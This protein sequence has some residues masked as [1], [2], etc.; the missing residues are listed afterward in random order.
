MC[1]KFQKGSSNLVDYPPLSSTTRPA[2]MSM[3]RVRELIGIP[4]SPALDKVYDCI[5]HYIHRFITHSSFITIASAHSDGT[6][7]CSPRGDYPGFVKVLDQKTLAIPD[8]VGNNRLDTFENLTTDP[9]IGLLFLV[10]GHRETLRVNGQAYLSEDSDVLARLEAEGKRPKVA[11]IVEVEEV[12]M[13]CG[14]ALIRSQLWDPASFALADHA[15]TLGQ[16]IA[17]RSQD[18]DIRSESIDERLKRSTYKNL[19]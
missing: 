11:I 6:A 10:A 2:R 17:A 15:P 9:R 3:K 19:Y 12:Y 4:D 8:R 13:H 5:D 14:R 18:R 1:D 16:V 7:D